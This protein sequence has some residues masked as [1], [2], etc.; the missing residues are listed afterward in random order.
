MEQYQKDL[1]EKWIIEINNNISLLDEEY[2][3]LELELKNKVAKEKVLKDASYSI[4]GHLREDFENHFQY[5]TL[6]EEIVSLKQRISEFKYH[7]KI[8]YNKT[9]LETLK[10]LLDFN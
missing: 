2:E 1:Y 4:Q 8:L 6:K 7:D 3:A 5:E 9:L 10:Q